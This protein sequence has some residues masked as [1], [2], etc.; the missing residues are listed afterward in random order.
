MDDRGVHTEVWK[1]W[2]IFIS[3]F[4]NPI[5]SSAGYDVRS[6]NNSEL[7]SMTIALSDNII[8][9]VIETKR[10]YR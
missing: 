6:Y 2:P 9:Q 8:T 4:Q 7:N 1:V 3:I 5:V 10:I